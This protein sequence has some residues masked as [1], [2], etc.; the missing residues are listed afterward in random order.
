MILLTGITGKTGAQVLRALS[1]RG[2]PLR[3]LVRDPDAAQRV[4]APHIELVQGDFG[5]AGSLEKAMRGVD[6]AFMVMPNAETQLQNEM[7]FVDAART[8]GVTRLVKLSAS[9]ADANAAALLKKYHGRS[10]AY[11]ARSGLAYTVVRP[12]FYMQ[13]LL[14]CARSIAADNQFRLP[15]GA[16]RTGL[17]DVRDVGEFVAS[18]LTG[19]GHDGQTYYITGPEIL[20]FGE[21]AQQMS[22]A[23]GRPIEYI[24]IPAREFG[25]GLRAAGVSEWY[26]DAVADLF[27][28]IANDG[29]ARTTAT[30]EEVCGRPPASFRQFVQR[31]AADF[32][33]A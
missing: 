16:G 32:A 18:V 3:A 30:F 10:E 28:I 19:S 24:D 22:D 7:R 31:H 2:L 26:I 4:A 1:G 15:M 14:Q 20:S 8:A 9:G 11:L 23:L 13:N 12:N 5:D 21:L 29:G 33:A 25:N 27:E 6:R 17:I